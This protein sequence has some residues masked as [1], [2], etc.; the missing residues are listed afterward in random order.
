M[1]PGP[2]QPAAGTLALYLRGP[3]FSEKAW[4]GAVWLQPPMSRLVFELSVD[5]SRVNPLLAPGP[6]SISPVITPHNDRV[7]AGGWLAWLLVAGAVGI[8]LR[9]QARSAALPNPPSSS[10]ADASLHD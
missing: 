7:I 9:R 2:T 10:T 8:R 5:H 6:I 1:L 3:Q 4:E